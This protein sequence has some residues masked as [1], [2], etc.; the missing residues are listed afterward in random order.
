MNM[1][2]GTS[3]LLIGGGYIQGGGGAS[4]NIAV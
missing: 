3:H 1:I 2:Y 4:K